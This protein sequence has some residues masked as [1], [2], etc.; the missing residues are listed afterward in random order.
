[1]SKE[2][3]TTF[4]P[5]AIPTLCRYE[6]FKRCLESLEK[7]T[8]ADKTD[9]YVGLDYPPS[10]KYV[11]GWEKIDKYLVEKEKQNGFQNLYVRRR[12]HNCGVG[13]PNSNGMLLLKEIQHLSDRYI[14]TED[15]NEFS[16]N[17]LQYMNWGL[18]EFRNDNSILAIC[19]FKRVDTST[20]KNNV[21]KYPRFNVWGYGQWYEKRDKLDK[22][23]DLSLL[24]SILDD[25]SFL[26]VFTP[27]LYKGASIIS[28]IRENVIYG[29][30][31]PA[32]LPKEEQ[33]CL[34]PTISMVK[35]H[36]QDGS[37]LHGGS[38]EGVELYEN[39][40]IDTSNEFAP[41]IVEDLYQPVL[42]KLYDKTYHKSLKR[43]M[44]CVM[45]FSLY[46][47]TGRVMV[48]NYKDPWYKVTLK[49]VR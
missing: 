6:H 40:V 34:F 44:R 3:I 18:Q 14:F 48:H 43:K 8:D 2:N 25:M 32:F 38:K 21:Y 5:V 1:M 41:R 13:N 36:G 29:D 22:Y 35:N 12:N 11:E 37:G 7:C 17:F 23:K 24:K 45:D 46:K 26:D 31:M 28:M 49:K 39:L 4:A 19:G 33:Y 9:V 47:L 27:N 30:F 42:K 10:E 20:L 16:P 15:D